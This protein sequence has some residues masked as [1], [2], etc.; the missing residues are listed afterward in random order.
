MIYTP[1]RVLRLAHNVVAYVRAAIWIGHAA[2]E[3]APPAATSQP[4]TAPLNPQQA[5]R[6]IAQD[7]GT[8]KG[9]G[10][11]L[12]DY[13]R[14]HKG[15][16]PHDLARCLHSKKKMPRSRS[17]SPLPIATPIPHRITLRPDW[18]NENASYNY[19]AADADIGKIP[20]TRVH[21]IVLAYTKTPLPAGRNRFLINYLFLDGHVEA[22]TLD[23][24]AQMLGDS[25]ALLQ[26]VASPETDK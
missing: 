12:L 18:V 6:R 2:A 21:S 17:L 3:D 20:V 7:A 25:V 10:E 1:I 19:F 15:V 4:A 11:V 8:L 14:Q 26:R 23:Q 16:L 13:Q 24:S 22:A 5:V 9:L